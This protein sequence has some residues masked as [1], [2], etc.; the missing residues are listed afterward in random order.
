M[1]GICGNLC[2]DPVPC[3]ADPAI[4]FEPAKSPDDALLSAPI[5]DLRAAFRLGGGRDDDPFNK[6]K[7]KNGL[8]EDG[9]DFPR[10][11][12]RRPGVRFYCAGVEDGR[13]GAP[14]ENVTPTLNVAAANPSMLVIDIQNRATSPRGGW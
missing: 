5:A 4:G 7:E 1:L 12:R 8:Q 14:A 11:I 3:F 10:G 6:P 9:D 13:F 2:A